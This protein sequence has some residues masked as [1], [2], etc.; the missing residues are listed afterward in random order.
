MGGDTLD[1]VEDVKNSSLFKI[2]PRQ[3]KIPTQNS[4]G[5]MAVTCSN[6]P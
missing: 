1:P 5:L 3:R 6:D 4:G 2:T